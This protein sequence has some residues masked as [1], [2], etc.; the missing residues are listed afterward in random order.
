MLSTLSDRNKFDNSY[1]HGFKHEEF[2]YINLIN[3]ILQHGSLE[4]GRN[5]YTKSIFGAAM[6]FSLEN[7][8]LPLLT[9]KKLAWKTCLKELL[10]FVQGKT[11]NEILKQQNV[12]I[13]SGN[14]DKEYLKTRNL[15]YDAGDLG[16]IYGHQWRHFNAEYKNCHTDYSDK[17]VDQLNN[18]ITLLKDPETRTSR[19][20]ILTSWNPQQLDEMALPPC[21]ILC[22]FNVIHD[23][24]LSCS[25][26][27]RSGDIGLGVPFNI[28][29]YSFLTHLIAKHCGL[30]PYKFIY[31]LGNAHIYDDHINSLETQILRKPYTFPNIDII[32]VK[33]DINDYTIDDFKVTNYNYHET[34]KMNMR[35]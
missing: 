6:E 7:N 31:F 32:N 8:T 30:E 14:A 22:Q 23:N 4:K 10:W 1:N 18:V 3:D 34:I 35:K 11:D 28:A 19:R 13:W 20:I 17:G 21:H 26:Y 2:Q 25:L 29:S 9:T 27:Q 12:N 33:N 15:N 24:K 5:G 16:P